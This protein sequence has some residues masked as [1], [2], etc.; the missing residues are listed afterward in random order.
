MARHSP[1]TGI[2]LATILANAG[3]VQAEMQEA[4]DRLKE[5]EVVGTSGGGTVKVTLG[6]DL[7]V[8]KVAI[9]PAALEGADAELIGELVQAAMND[10]MRNAQQLAASMLGGITAGGRLPEGL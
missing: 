7:L 1:H 5:S 8:R 2:D 3:A 9:E 10:A 6:G 4:Q